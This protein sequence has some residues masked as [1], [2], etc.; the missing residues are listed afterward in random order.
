MIYSPAEAVCMTGSYASKEEA[1][2]K[3]Y[4]CSPLQVGDALEWFDCE[5]EIDPI[6]LCSHRLYKLPQKT[7]VYPKPGFELHHRQGDAKYARMYTDVGVY[8]A[9]G[10]I[11]RGEL[12]DE[13]ETVCQIEN[14]GFQPQYAVPE[15]TEK[16][17]WRVYDA[18]L[19]EHRRR[20]Y[21]AAGTF[22]SVY[23]KSKQGKK[24]KKE[25]QEAEQAVLDSSYAEVDRPANCGAAAMGNLQAGTA[26]YESA[27]IIAQVVQSNQEREEKRHA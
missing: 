10:L 7:M 27:S 24:T 21:G 11:L 25:V 12:F 5:M 16:N 20:K 6:W 22:M 8:Y 9:P 14:H 3:G 23:Y 18:C 1:K 26:I 15:L 2:K 19:Y 4:A 13:V 17:S